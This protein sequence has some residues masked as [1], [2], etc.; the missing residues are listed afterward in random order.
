MVPH[1]IIPMTR[2]QMRNS[3]ETEA[4]HCVANSKLVCHSPGPKASHDLRMQPRPADT[5]P[6]WNPRASLNLC[7]FP[8]GVQLENSSSS[9]NC[10]LTA[11]TKSPCCL[12]NTWFMC[13]GQLQPSLLRVSLNAEI[14]LLT[15]WAQGSPQFLLCGMQKG[16]SMCKPP[17]LCWAEWVPTASAPSLFHMCLWVERTETLPLKWKHTI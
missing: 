3:L 10:V 15:L 8:A 2:N 9:K 1:L 4:R 6:L 13:L 5:S 11:L 14:V 7:I 16:S 12:Q 17:R